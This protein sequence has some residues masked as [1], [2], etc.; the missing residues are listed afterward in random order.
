MYAHGIYLYNISDYTF[1]EC[2]ISPSGRRSCKKSVLRPG[3]G[4]SDIKRESNLRQ[5]TTRKGR[6]QIAAKKAIPSRRFKP[7]NCSSVATNSIGF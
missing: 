7:I 1:D 3:N 2:V 6:Q 4:W 5:S